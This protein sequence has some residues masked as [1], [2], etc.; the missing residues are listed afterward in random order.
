MDKMHRHK[1]TQTR[2]YACTHFSVRMAEINWWDESL[3]VIAPA[4]CLQVS[5]VSFVALA[6]RLALSFHRDT[7]TH[8]SVRMA[9]I[10]WWN[11]LLTLDVIFFALCL[12]L[13]TWSITGIVWRA[14]HYV[15][16]FF[17]SLWHTH[18]HTYANNMIV[19]VQTQTCFH[20]TRG[21]K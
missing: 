1:Q 12:L 7:H 10:D 9:V 15:W 6:N 13:L 19:H 11:G 20:Q 8:T 17:F 2:M 5:L 21:T 3:A 14:C 16:H 18:V 4:L